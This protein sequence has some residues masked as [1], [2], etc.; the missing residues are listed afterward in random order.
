MKTTLI[1]TIPFRAAF[2]GC[3]KVECHRCIY[4]AFDECHYNAPAADGFPH[5]E[6]RDFCRHF[7]TRADVLED[8]GA[9]EN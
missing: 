6:A 7:E 8:E 4:C 5:V 1:A 9:N 2:E 3:M